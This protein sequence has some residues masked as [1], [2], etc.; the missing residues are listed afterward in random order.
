METRGV[1]T[2]SATLSPLHSTEV[3]NYA[4]FMWFT[5]IDIS[6]LEKKYAVMCD[7]CSCYLSK[8]DMTFDNKW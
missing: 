7:E 8:Q 3:E 1:F 6:L 4:I 2:A 5:R